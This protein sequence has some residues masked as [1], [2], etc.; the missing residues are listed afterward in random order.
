MSIGT[1]DKTEQRSRDNTVDQTRLEGQKPK[2]V[3]EVDAGPE[4]QKG[5]GTEQPNSNMVGIPAGMPFRAE[6]RSERRAS[7]P[8]KERVYPK[9][10]IEKDRPA[11]VK[12]GPAAEPEPNKLTPSQDIDRTTEPTEE[13]KLRQKLDRLGQAAKEQKP[14]AI[15]ALRDFLDE[16]P[17]IYK[18]LGDTALAARRGF[19]DLMAEHHPVSREAIAKQS[20]ALLKEYLPGDGH[21]PTER[22]LAEQVVVSYLRVNFFDFQSSNHAMSTNM[23]LS[24]LLLKKEEQAQNSLQK[25]LSK[26]ET[27]RR[28]KS[29]PV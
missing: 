21:C 29:K 19:A 13:F 2:K 18:T 14:G 23:K 3:T 1:I 17:F 15:G 11:K 12:E 20:E 5:L 26:L 8:K 27:Y 28:L 25:A 22:I 9:P 16:H 24:N 7:K 10:P 6:P 4:G